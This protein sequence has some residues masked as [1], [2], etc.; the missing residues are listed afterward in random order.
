MSD[1]PTSK[2]FYSFQICIKKRTERIF[3]SQRE[4]Q[5]LPRMTLFPLCLILASFIWWTGKIL[6]VVKG[7][8]EPPFWSC[9]NYTCKPRTV[10]LFP[11]LGK[12]WVASPTRTDTSTHPC[13]KASPL[14]FSGREEARRPLWKAQEQHP[15]SHKKEAN[16]T[17]KI[18]KTEESSL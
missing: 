9:E 18:G 15:G 5:V 1:K 14:L 11:P 6:G 16:V 7:L 4:R 13:W 3:A 2:F 17:G 12:N 8:L 10:S